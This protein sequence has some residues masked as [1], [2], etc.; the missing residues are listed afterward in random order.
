[1]FLSRNTVV[2]ISYWNCFVQVDLSYAQILFRSIDTNFDNCHC[3]REFLFHFIPKIEYS[4]QMEFLS[5]RNRQT[6]KTTTGI[7]SVLGT[8]C[9]L[10]LRN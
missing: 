1:M 5:I 2:L 10:S 9:A 7:I 4:K 6:C 3:P 8:I